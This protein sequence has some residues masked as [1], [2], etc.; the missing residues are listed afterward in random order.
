MYLS[1][2]DFKGRNDH[3]VYRPGFICPCV[4]KRDH[5]TQNEVNLA[6]PPPLPSCQM[7][8]IGGATL[9]VLSVLLVTGLPL[10]AHASG[11]GLADLTSSASTSLNG[12][13]AK[14]AASGFL[15]VMVMMMMMMTLG[16]G[17]EKMMMMMV[18]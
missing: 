9:A 11:M 7:R 6:L 10:A 1:R 2:L 18:S 16:S 15:Q 17:G 12:A 4:A 8:H 13:M 3:P 5:H 14:L